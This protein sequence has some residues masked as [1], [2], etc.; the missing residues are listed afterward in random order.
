MRGALRRLRESCWLGV[1]T[2]PKKRNTPPPPGE[3]VAF[4]I[5]RDHQLDD[6]LKIARLYHF[7]GALPTAR[8]W[9]Q[10]LLL[11]AE[12]ERGR[13]HPVTLGIAALL[14]GVYHAQGDK[15]AAVALVITR[16]KGA[17]AG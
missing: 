11:M 16:S 12:R 8:K 6:M 7:R 1:L 4:Q 2:H 15:G 5:R 13:D 17:M 14:I 3:Q 10:D 9:Y